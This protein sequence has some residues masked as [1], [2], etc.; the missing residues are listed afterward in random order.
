[1]KYLLIDA[2]IAAGYYLPRAVSDQETAKRIE[3]ILDNAREKKDDFFVYIPNFC[4]AETISVFI[5]HS[6]GKWNKH[7]RNNPIDTRVYKSLIKSFQ[8]DIHNGKFINHY[9]LNRYHILGI[10]FVAPFDHY[11]QLNRKKGNSKNNPTPAGTFDHLII[12]MGIQLAKIHKP[13]N[14]FILT[15]DYRLAKILDKCKSKIEKSTLDKLK[16]NIAEEICSRDFSKHL[17]PEHLDLKQCS[18]KDLKK[19]FGEWPL[20]YSKPGRKVYKWRK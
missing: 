6:F 4:I 14:V 11:Y 8:S 20:D 1:M 12:S 19:V 16:I 13:E 2:N 3:I 7:V 10:N 15:T 5:K 9:E 17:F 18:T